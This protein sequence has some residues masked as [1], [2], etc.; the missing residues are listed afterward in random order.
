MKQILNRISLVLIL[1]LAYASMARVG[2]PRTTLDNFV[3]N[4]MASLTD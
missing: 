2:F 4:T 3:D 1:A